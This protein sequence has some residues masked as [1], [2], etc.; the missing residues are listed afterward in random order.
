MDTLYPVLQ[1]NWQKNTEPEEKVQHLASSCLVS[2]RVSYLL[3]AKHLNEAVYTYDPQNS[4]ISSM[5]TSGQL[6]INLATSILMTKLYNRKF[7]AFAKQLPSSQILP[8]TVLDLLV[9][10]TY[11]QENMT[12]QLYHLLG[13]DSD[14]SILLVAKLPQ[15]EDFSSLRAYDQLIKTVQEDDDPLVPFTIWDDIYDF[16]IENHAALFEI[17]DG[18]VFDFDED[19]MLSIEAAILYDDIDFQTLDEKDEE[20][21]KYYYLQ[22][23]RCGVQRTDEERRSISAISNRLCSPLRCSDSPFTPSELQLITLP[24]Y[25][26]GIRPLL[27]LMLAIHPSLLSY[28]SLDKLDRWK[29]KEIIRLARCRGL[30]IAKHVLLGKISPDSDIASTKKHPSYESVDKVMENYQRILHR[31]VKLGESRLLPIPT[32]DSISALIDERENDPAHLSSIH[33]PLFQRYTLLEERGAA[34]IFDIAQ[35]E[36]RSTVPYTLCTDITVKN[37]P[38]I[39]DAENPPNPSA[40]DSTNTFLTDYWSI[41]IPKCRYITPERIRSLWNPLWSLEE[42]TLDIIPMDP[43]ELIRT[44]AEKLFKEE[45]TKADARYNNMLNEDPAKP[46]ATGSTSGTSVVKRQSSV[47]TL[48]SKCACGSFHAVLLPSQSSFQPQTLHQSI[49]SMSPYYTPPDLG[50]D[51]SRDSIFSKLVLHAVQE[52]CL[53]IREYLDLLA[54]ANKSQISRSRHESY[55]YIDEAVWGYIVSSIPVNDTYRHIKSNVSPQLWERKSTA[56]KARFGPHPLPS[57]SLQVRIES[58]T[59]EDAVSVMRRS[60]K[61]DPHILSAVKNSSLVKNV[62]QQSNISK[63]PSQVAVLKGIDMWGT[64][65]SLDARIVEIEMFLTILWEHYPLLNPLLIGDVDN[66]C[67]QT[68]YC[69]ASAYESGFSAIHELEEVRCI[70]FLLRQGRSLENE[71]LDELLMSQEKLRMLSKDC[72]KRRIRAIKMLEIERYNDIVAETEELCALYINTVWGKANHTDKR[73]SGSRMTHEMQI[74]GAYESDGCIQND[75]GEFLDIIEDSIRANGLRLGPRWEND[76]FDYKDI[77]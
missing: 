58:S 25:H 30:E 72:M 59:V 20:T 45:L 32:L 14:K 51:V 42:R 29:S 38:L 15:A 21:A 34:P 52:V 61:S 67:F 28:G 1:Q 31:P 54:N 8:T 9:T 26:H 70:K 36:L 17:V 5:L 23:R 49:F 55:R 39:P 3:T 64:N 35:R 68:P 74:V 7:S 41:S 65:T 57:H 18:C 75:L 62:I 43:S 40:E 37:T 19:L 44:P 71:V 77:M 69:I 46:D 33:A 47:Q 63:Y 11:D 56:P 2:N 76:G 60:R 4:L 53:L 48:S 66:R 27:N 73:S 12:K 6:S 10:S 13:C 16:V 50:D 22:E 24:N